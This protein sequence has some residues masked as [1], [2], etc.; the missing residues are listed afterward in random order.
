MSS[1][2]ASKSSD[3]SGS[4][5]D[6]AAGSD[7]ELQFFSEL[8][9]EKRAAD[10]YDSDESYWPS[11]D[12]VAANPHGPTLVAERQARQ[13]QIDFGAMAPNPHDMQQAMQFQ[14]NITQRKAPD[15][16]MTAQIR[17]KGVGPNDAIAVRLSSAE[18]QAIV[19]FSVPSLG[20]IQARLV[21][22][23]MWRDEHGALWL[24]TCFHSAS[25]TYWKDWVFDGVSW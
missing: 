5:T 14:D 25:E 4:H 11:D 8:S 18:L 12:P 6:D 2:T 22:C 21:L 17:Q 16:A 10:K 19:N 3:G 13:G 24:R 20:L 1:R 9:E 7:E 15:A 23:F